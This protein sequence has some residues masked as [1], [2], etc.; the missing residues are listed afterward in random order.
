[1][2]PSPI[3]RRLRALSHLSRCLFGL[4]MGFI[5]LGSPPS[6]AAQT[7]AEGSTAVNNRGAALATDCTT[8]LGLKDTLR[9]TASLNWATTLNMDSWDGITVEGTPARVTWLQLRYKGLTGSLP[10]A[11]TSLTGLTVLTLEFSQLSG[12]IP[13]LSALTSLTYLS[14]KDNQLSGTIP[15][16]SALTNLTT[17][18]L[19]HNQLS[20]SI[21]ALSALTNL[22]TLALSSNQLSGSVPNLSA[23]TNLTTLALSSNQ[24]SSV[25]NTHLPTSLTTLHLS[26]NQLSG[27]IP[28]LSALTN[29]TTLTLGSQYDSNSNATL[30]AGPIPTW[31]N[32][33]TKLTDLR[34]EETNRTGPIPA[35]SA[36]TS[37]TY[38]RLYRNRLSSVPNTHLPASL[39][40]LFLSQN[41]LSGSVPNLGGVIS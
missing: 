9:G 33:L 36:L 7:C 5:F 19:S 22:T 23:L 20:G 6:V 39:T 24:L 13:N 40:T 10:T 25:P 8:L 35:L 27:S 34:L 3:R 32:S 26:R 29:L 37:L 18:D 17:L 30:T 31:V 15:A 38:L 14:F 11:L 28:N 41:Q 4:L 12:S 1:M 21:P 2:Y 16:L